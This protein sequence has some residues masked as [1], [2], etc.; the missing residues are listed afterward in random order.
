MFRSVKSHK[1]GILD[2]GFWICF[3]GFGVL[4]L[5]GGYTMAEATSPET[6]EAED[7]LEIEINRLI[8]DGFAANTRDGFRGT[9]IHIVSDRIASEIRRLIKKRVAEAT[10]PETLMA[11]DPLEMEINRLIEDGFAANTRDG[12]R[13]TPIHEV[14]ERI[15]SQIRHLIKKRVAEAISPETLMAEAPLEMEINRLVAARSYSIINKR[16]AE[17]TSPETLMVED[18]LELE[19]NRLI[20]DGFAANTRDGFAGTPIHEVSN[21]IA[22]QIR[23][24]IKKRVGEARSPETLMAK[25]SLELEINRLVAARRYSIIKKSV[26]GNA[27]YDF[28]ETPLHV[29]AS[30]GNKDL[31]EKLI[32]EGA[33]VNVRGGFDW[34]PLHFV[35]DGG[36]RDLVD[37]FISKGADV[38]ARTA[39][40]WTPL[41]KAAS[42]GYSDVTKLLISKG[43]DVNVWS[44]NG[45]GPIH[46]AAYA[47]H[48]ETVELLISEGADVNA[49][50]VNGWNSQN[51]EAGLDKIEG[52]ERLISNCPKGNFARNIGRH[53]GREVSIEDFSNSLVYENVGWT[54][55]HYAAYGGNRDVVELLVLKGADVVAMDISCR[56]PL[57]YANLER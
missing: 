32:S 26:A 34:T 22:S 20:E 43:A 27:Q 28:V 49:V 39:H 10:S 52:Y 4:V 54:P 15:A 5:L 42:H 16:V 48:V 47:G 57:D 46:A 36:Y 30:E 23:R 50:K 8:E 18:P 29:A 44:D 12:F 51:G 37:L 55:L 3:L 38:N 40:G 13:G 19:I 7:P 41:H 21:K 45:M 24:N 11:K 35:T 1:L 56:T 6:F 33:D 14:S 17:A 9:P 25:N 2:F 53:P 31:A